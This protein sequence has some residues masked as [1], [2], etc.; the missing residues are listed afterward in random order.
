[1]LGLEVDAPAYGVLELVAL[2]HGIL[3]DLD[4]VG[5]AHAGKVGAGN[6]LETVFEALVDEAVE[7]VELIRALVHDRT[8]HELEHG[9]GALHVALEVA[10]CH[11]RLD[12]PE[13]GSMPSRIRVLGTE[14]R[15]ERVDIAEAH[16]EVLCLELAG[17]REVRRLAEEVLRPVDRA[18]RVLRNIRE[19]ERRDTEHLAGTLCI[20]C[21]DDR[22][23][24][25][26]E[27]ALLEERV[28]GIGC[29]GADAED[30]T[31][32]VRA[33]TEVLLRAQ[34]LAR[35]TLLLHRVVRSRRALDRDLGSL[36]L[37]G[38]RTVWRE[39]ERAGDD[40]RC[41]HIL[42]HD[43]LIDIL[44]ECVLVEDDL[45]VLEAAAVIQDDEAKVLHV[46]DGTDP[47]CAGDSRAAELVRLLVE[48]SDPCT[49]Q[50]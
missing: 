21:R 1:M 10:E 34:E 37:E 32:E 47:A 8:D 39:R 25:I 3:E 6:M 28:D 5:V 30:G 46:A 20:G 38:L 2:L 44:A 48:Q 13:L 36:E 35:R 40:K 22:R 18:I 41:S 4:C 16:C 12:H 45:Q 29:D 15:P 11:L 7:H 14:R 26:D 49:I 24:H 23:V 17:D 43:V 19:V 9:L 33:G 31:K 42:G 50:E 27:A